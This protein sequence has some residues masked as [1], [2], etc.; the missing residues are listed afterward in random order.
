MDS[1]THWK[2]RP[3]YRSTSVGRCN[4]GQPDILID[5][6]IANTL[7]PQGAEFYLSRFTKYLEQEPGAAIVPYGSGWIVHRPPTTAGAYPH[8]LEPASESTEFAAENEPT[9]QQCREVFDC[10]VNLETGTI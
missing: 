5:G 8:T 2:V 3:Y 10:Q 1:T 6:H 7:L 9:V 4:S